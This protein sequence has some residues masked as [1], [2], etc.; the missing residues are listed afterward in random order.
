MAS[1]QIELCSRA[2]VKLGA[3][4]ISS[5][6]DG[7]LEAEVAASLYSIVRDYLLTTHP[8]NFATMYASPPRLASAPI[9]GFSSAFLLPTDC[10][11]VISAGY[12]LRARGLTYKIVGRQLHA[13]SDAVVICYIGRPPE[14]G[15]PP[16]F[17][18][19][20]ITHLAAEFC[21]PLTESTSRWES[22]RRAASLEL[23]Q[24][25]LIDAQEDTPAAIEDFSLIESRF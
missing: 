19:A 2:L 6:D 4:S 18:A 17:E 20:L 15:F 24:A 23:Q 12:G 13:N 7:T 9:P 14:T 3:S 21:I 10:L 5:F 16:F 22:L 1:S 8:W 11:R 25:R